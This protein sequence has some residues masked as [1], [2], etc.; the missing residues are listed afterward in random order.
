MASW[1]SF[2]W[3]VRQHGTREWFSRAFLLAARTPLG[4]GL[5]ALEDTE[6]KLE[7]LRSDLGD[8]GW[9]LHLPTGELVAAG[10]SEANE[11]G[12][13]L[14]PDAT[15]E[16]Y[17]RAQ[18]AR[19]LSGEITPAQA[20]REGTGRLHGAALPVASGKDEPTD[21]DYSRG[22]NAYRGIQQ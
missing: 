15:D 5:E 9:S 12:D 22:W 19:L 10:P 11:N 1:T 21:D 6:M 4:G 8:G 17:A 13:W 20:V 18:A 2:S 3:R 7:L 14:R 16:A